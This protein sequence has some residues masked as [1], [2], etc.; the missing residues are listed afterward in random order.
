MPTY[1]VHEPPLRK[2][3]SL[4]EAAPDLE[5]FVFVRDGFHFWAL[6]LG[7]LWML[8]HRM[9]L[10]LVL[11]LIANAALAA[12]FFALRAPPGARFAAML[13]LALLVGFEAAT[14]RRFTLRIWRV[15][16]VVV[17]NDEESAERRFFASWIAREPVVP[18][19]SNAKVPPAPPVMRG[20]PTPGHVIGLFPEPGGSR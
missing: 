4:G 8:A 17:G 19:T 11:Y 15:A 9:W 14:L 2:A 12:V 10:V 5:R 18:V 16:G 6:L 7:P 13:L 1:T 20:P 3:T